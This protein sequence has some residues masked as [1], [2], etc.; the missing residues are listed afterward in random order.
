MT[1]N[2]T[3]VDMTRVRRRPE[4][5]GQEWLR[6]YVLIG[7]RNL[8]TTHQVDDGWILDFDYQT[9]PID[10]NGSRGNHHAH[11]RKVR[12]VRK[13]AH[14]AADGIPPLGRFRAQLTWFVFS[15]GRRDPINLSPTIKAMVDGLID[16]GLA[17]D[18]TANYVDTPTARIV[19]V[20]PK[21]NARQWMELEITRWAGLQ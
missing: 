16:A 3:L 18:D 4:D 2:R 17:L 19:R 7:D 20:D 9:K 15:N 1:E 6:R 21:L 14:D 8:P 11:A 10:P 5:A 13:A 12:G